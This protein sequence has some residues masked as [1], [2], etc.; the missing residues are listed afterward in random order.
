MLPF[1]WIRLWPNVRGCRPYLELVWNRSGLASFFF[2][3]FAMLAT[4]VGWQGA[5]SIQAGRSASL[6]LL[7][8]EGP[9]PA[10]TRST[11]FPSRAFFLTVEQEQLSQN[12]PWS[13]SLGE[14][15]GG[16]AQLCGCSLGPGRGPY[17]GRLPS[18]HVEHTRDS[19]QATDSSSRQV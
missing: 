3:I 4:T 1:S 5:R 13:V 19:V 17:H 10:S 11:G 8:G 18:E 2:P 16:S 12:S 9:R 14:G 15:L 6:S 7:T